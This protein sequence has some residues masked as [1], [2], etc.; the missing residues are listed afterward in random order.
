[1]QPLTVSLIQT[2]TH[3]HSPSGNRTLFERLFA[4]VPDDA[5]IVVLPEMFSTGFTMSTAEVAEPIGGPTLTWLREQA[6]EFGKVICG[7]LV[8][9]ENGCYYNRFV[10]VTSE[11]SVTSYDKRHLFRMTDE[12]RHYTAGKQRRTVV[13]GEWRVCPMICYDLRFPVWFRNR[14]DYD[15][16]LCVAN[17]P[18]ERQQI[19]NTLLRARAVE[20]QCYCVGLNIVGTDGNG[21]AYSGGSAIYTAEGNV[22]LEAGELAGVFTTSLEGDALVD[23]RRRFP[24]WQDADE[25][26]L[27]D[28]S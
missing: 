4:E 3:W 14:G 8:I 10:W 15:V 23:Y 19:W 17:W 13:V 25:F 12:H 1:M 26:S 6:V 18:A 16:L 11:G 7:S 20:N 9:V 27:A 21:V 5:Q 22:L 24:A 28:E 2:A